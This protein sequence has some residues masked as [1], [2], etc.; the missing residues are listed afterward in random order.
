MVIES[1]YA[2]PAGTRV[3]WYEI[4]SV[5]GQGSFGITY[6]AHDHN[7]NI[8]VAIKEYLPLE[9]AIRD[10][11]TT[12]HPLTKNHGEIYRWGLARFMAEAKTLARFKHHNIV[13]VNAVFE[14]NN[15]A[16]MVM[17]YERGEAL[18]HLFNSGEFTNESALLSILLPLL[19]GL[20]LIHGAGFIHRDIKPSNIYIRE[21]HS[22]VLLDFGSARHALGNKSKALTSLVTHGYAPLEQYYEVE[23]HQGPW[24]DLYALG[25]TAYL[26]IS[27][28]VPTNALLRGRALISNLP[29]PYKS[30]REIGAKRYTRHFLAAVDRALMLK[31]SDRPQ[32]AG[33]WKRMLLGEIAAFPGMEDDLE[34]IVIQRPPHETLEKKRTLPPIIP[35]PRRTIPGPE[36]PHRAWFKRRRLYIGL[37]TGL[38]AIILIFVYIGQSTNEIKALLYEA[39]AF[40]EKQKWQDALQIY[41]KVLARDPENEQANQAIGKL[42]LR[43]VELA[44]VAIENG[45]IQTAQSHLDAAKRLAP[46]MD[47]IK[48]AEAKLAKLREENAETERKHAAIEKLGELVK[49]A[50]G[51]LKKIQASADAV[52]ANMHASKFYRDAQRLKLQANELFEKGENYYEHEQLD[53]ASSAMNQSLDLLDRA[54]DHFLEAR[55]SAVL[56]IN[57]LEAKRAETQQLHLSIEQA[58]KQLVAARVE[59]DNVKA[60]DLAPN[61]YAAAV[62]KKSQAETLIT[63]GE[64]SN[65][66]SKFDE[67][68]TTLGQALPLINQSR[69]AFEKARRS[70]KNKVVEVEQ[71]RTNAKQLQASLNDNARQ[72]AEK[73]PPLTQQDMEVVSKLIYKFKL[74]YEQKDLPKIL[75]MT[76][77]SSERYR[78]TE[79]IFK[80]YREIKV[81][82]SNFKLM[83]HDN[84][85][86]AIVTIDKLINFN[87]DSVTPSDD[88]KEAKIVVKKRNNQWGK[89]TW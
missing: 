57:Q 33:E 18:N 73:E 4:R 64:E 48:N 74:A 56:T 83:A 87:G 76:R 49:G 45:H 23:G 26:G 8:N 9:F 78:L 37:I 27:G 46:D 53:E 24:S 21:D 34:T 59:A 62:N 41:R 31:E 61:L 44:Q 20:K 25:A 82:I 68:I 70:A 79:S 85:A 30:A 77:M 16:Y 63:Q 3:H 72:S 39:D 84:S 86:S 15:T 81:T 36:R 60:N 55:S 42:A 43:R 17:E 69:E 58:K 7:L 66:N 47:E 6:L 50:L 88:W 22:P 12:V 14:Q 75:K 52:G 54:S 67:A 2:L 80:E 40:V 51:Q 35:D 29:D 28:E 10:R 71:K 13:R 89:I 19:D 32:T 1:P 5:L 11:D 38:T 65:K